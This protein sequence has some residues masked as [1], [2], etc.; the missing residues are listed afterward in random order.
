MSSATC[1]DPD[2]LA[3]LLE[4]EAPEAMAGYADHLETCGQCQQTVADLSEQRWSWQEVVRCLQPADEDSAPSEPALTRVMTQLKS[5]LSL[6]T[7]SDDETSEEAE[8]A[9]AILRPSERPELLGTLGGY[10]VHEI[11]GRG[12]M[13]V[14][15]KALDPV[16][17]RQV[18]IKLMAGAAASG[19]AARR[20]FMREA[21]AAA[22]VC[23]DHLVTLFGVHE[24][25]GVPY[26]VMQYVAG[27]SLQERLDRS[28]PLQILEAV[29]IAQQTAAGLAAAH[30][31]GLIHRDIKPAN[32]LLEQ[33]EDRVK[34][35]DFGLARTPQDVGL[36]QA[37]VVAGTPE[38]MAPEQA[39]GEPV[40][41][42]ADL[43]S[44]GCVLFAMCTG[45]P[46]FRAAT[47]LAVLRQISDE[48]APPLRSVNPQVPAWLASL[49]ERLLAKDPA[50]RIQSAAEVA[51]LLEGY[52]AHLREPA[53]TPAPELPSTGAGTQG[54]RRPPRWTLGLAACLG[55]A[56]SL[57]GLHGL[58]Y[59]FPGAA[60]GLGVVHFDLRG[61]APDGQL[62][63][64]AGPNAFELCK[65][66]ADGLRISLPP[67]REHPWPV[68]IR[69]SFPV[70]GDCEITTSYELVRADRP[71]T[72]YG[73]GAT[74][75]IVA[76]GPAKRAAMIGRLNR[77]EGSDYICDHNWTNDLD[78]RK[79]QRNTFP[80]DVTSGKLR[81]VR[82]GQAVSYQVQGPGENEF[83]ELQ[84]IQFGTED[85]VE[86]RV[87]CDTGNSTSP[88]EI[89]IRDFDIQAADLP[90]GS[91]VPKG[92][93]FLVVLGIATLIATGGLW[94]YFRRR[95]PEEHRDSGGTALPP[96]ASTRTVK[97]IARFAGPA[98]LLCMAVGLGVSWLSSG[99]AEKASQVSAAL[100]SERGLYQDFR[101][102]HPLMPGLALVGKDADDYT[103]RGPEGYRVTLP[104]GRKAT[105][106]LLGVG[107]L[108][109]FEVRGDFQITGSFDLLAADAPAGPKDV[110][111]VELFIMREPDGKHMAR[112]GRFNTSEGQVY[113]V[114]DS[115]F[116]ALQKGG[117][118]RIVREPTQETQGKL[119]LV[120]RGSMLTY[121]VQD[122]TTQGQFKELFKT[123]FGTEPLKVLLYDVYPGDH[124]GTVDA[125]LVDFRV[126]RGSEVL[127][128]AVAAPAVE[129][130]PGAGQR[131]IWKIVFAFGLLL[132][133]LVGGGLALRH[134]RRHDVPDTSS[135]VP[136]PGLAN[137]ARVFA[138]AACGKRLKVRAELEG[139]RVKCPQCG[140]AVTVP[141]GRT[142]VAF[143]PGI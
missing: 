48:P 23:H 18:A 75:Y 86:V 4:S 47:P 64:F 3:A 22:T 32:V 38:Y 15:F 121:L 58:G 118:A 73:V 143:R 77:P 90:T 14:V 101:N 70:K 54:T 68:G 74:L 5:E 43:F 2:A 26:L 122:A 112:L 16:L 93:W 85:L 78:K 115:D 133:S 95:R 27:E 98:A 31:Q 67:N 25:A 104:A 126:E 80:S 11:I 131:G 102:Q 19:A 105:R 124:F 71:F 136:A 35:T 89:L 60:S 12:G 137:A 129:P 20:R 107:V 91:P 103:K 46:P 99:A 51:G 45:A 59:I 13:G 30:A 119:R 87:A 40:D 28:G 120:R 108:S 130:A 111:G 49:V 135:D 106:P 56:L 65:T 114:R 142:E 100:A 139:K 84:Q 61:R 128:Q 41:Q 79:Y 52:L 21:Q 50:Q 66:E 88:G 83:R 132:V 37:G 141:S 140:E 44:L 94:S 53:T 34:I 63:D 97:N 116:S 6:L 138:C 69:A 55:V 57:V 29:R 96:S 24:A 17:N 1:L 109:S 82:K 110:V 127:A 125:R 81:L 92:W 8:D 36:T 62:L 76:D 123:E 39:R 117:P 33:G 10:E 42:R 7:K 9:L 134:A 72:G 113:E